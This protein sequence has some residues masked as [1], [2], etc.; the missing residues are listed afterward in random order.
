MVWVGPAKS[1]ADARWSW[2]GKKGLSEG[3]FNVWMGRDVRATSGFVVDC[4]MCTC[5]RHP[6]LAPRGVELGWKAGLHM[7]M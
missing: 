7:T 4:R 6:P 5:M 2:I 3:R 1:I